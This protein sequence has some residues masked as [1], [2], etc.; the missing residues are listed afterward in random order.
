MTLQE[1]A[2]WAELVTAF[3]VIPTLLLVA[4]ELHAANRQ[5]K[6]SNTHQV[7]SGIRELK[8]WGKSP[9]LAEIITRGRCGF[10]QLSDAEKFIF[11]NYMEEALTA[12]DSFLLHTDSNILKKGEAELAAIGAFRQFLAHPGAQEWWEQSGL[13]KRWPSHLLSAVA[14]ALPQKEKEAGA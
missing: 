11:T 6:R 9:E 12:Y 10:H 13:Q 2:T 5:A 1:M 7:T 4:W 3:G 8:S 14:S